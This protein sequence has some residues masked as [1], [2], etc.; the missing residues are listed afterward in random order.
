VAISLL[1]WVSNWLLSPGFFGAALLIVACL[2]AWIV[3]RLEK[4]TSTGRRLYWD[5]R[6][7]AET[8]RIDQPETTSSGFS[9]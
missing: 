9:A 6:I 3:R 2:F 8:D 1:E 5:A 4:A 7:A